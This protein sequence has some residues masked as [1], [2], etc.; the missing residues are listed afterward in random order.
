MK[1]AFFCACMKPSGAFGRTMVRPYIDAAAQKR[2]AE[3]PFL[4]E[5][6]E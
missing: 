2:G 1:A 5:N 3:A 4:M 6:G